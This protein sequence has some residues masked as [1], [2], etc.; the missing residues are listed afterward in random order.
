[1]SN[2]PKRSVISTRDQIH[3]IHHSWV[4][5]KAEIVVHRINHYPANSVVCFVNTYP[6]ACV[7]GERWSRYTPSRAR[8]GIRER[9][10]RLFFNPLATSPL[11][12]LPKQKHSREIPPATQVIIHWIAIYP[13]DSVIQ[14]SNCWGQVLKWPGY[15]A[16]LTRRVG[17]G[18]TR[19]TKA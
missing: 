13:M 7:A 10:T 3:N 11:A 5:R 19:Q 8:V 17:G 9:Q 16:F 2:Q 12:S 15:E 6:L 1:M 14:P 18:S 4:V